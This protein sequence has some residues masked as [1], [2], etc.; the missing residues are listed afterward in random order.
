[1]G[2]ASSR[3]G[4]AV[5]LDL[6]VQVVGLDEVTRALGATETQAKRA[7][8]VAVRHASRWANMRAIRVVAAATKVKAK[9]LRG[10][11]HGD[12]DTVTVDLSPV[13]VGLLEPRASGDGITAAGRAYP[14]GFVRTKSG[15]PV[16]F[17]RRGA[18]R[19]PID[20]LRQP[21]LAEGERALGRLS[22]AAGAELLREFDRALREEM[23][24][25]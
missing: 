3:C 22:D 15:G 6:D 21:I 8:R 18:E 7:I 10:R 20:V 4:A 13:D 9:V 17:R 12:A 1:M 2:R 24:R 19:Y 23:A 25:G 14:G 16:A 11:Q 5:P